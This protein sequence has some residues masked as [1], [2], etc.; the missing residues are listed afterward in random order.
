[1]SYRA[2]IVRCV[3]DGTF[4]RKHV[5]EALG[6]LRDKYRKAGWFEEC[7][8][9]LEEYKRGDC[10]GEDYIEFCDFKH[11]HYRRVSE[12]LNEIETK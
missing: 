6:E 11:R 9:K 3:R 10:S 4:F 7:I 1:M 2:H 8:D 12:H 5:E